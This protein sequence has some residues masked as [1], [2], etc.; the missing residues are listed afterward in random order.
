MTVLFRKSMPSG[1]TPKQKEI[2]ELMSKGGYHL[3]TNEGSNYKCWLE[4][5]GTERIYINRRTA[6]ALADKD[7][8][9]PDDSYR[10]KHF[11]AWK[12]K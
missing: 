1:L 5:S 2:F 3:L 11:F 12:L 10:T 6:N 7:I 8:I 9:I 4:K